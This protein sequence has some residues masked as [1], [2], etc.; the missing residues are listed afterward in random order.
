M[1]DNIVIE[2]VYDESKSEASARRV[3]EKAARG[4]N[5]GFQPVFEQGLSKRELA[6]LRHA[7]RLMQMHERTLQQSAIIE[8]RR[9]SALDTTRARNE[10]AEAATVHEF[11]IGMHSHAL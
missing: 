10:A 2:I 3:G 9:L 8:Q 6:E 11:S 5:A 7:Q 1:P 4:H